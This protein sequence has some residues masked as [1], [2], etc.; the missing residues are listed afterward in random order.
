MK[1]SLFLILIFQSSFI[2]FD[3]N[4]N[5]QSKQKE[6]LVLG[7]ACSYNR[8]ISYSKVQIFHS[9]IEAENT[10]NKIMQFVSLP[11]NFI[12]K[13][14]NVDNAAATILKSGNTFKRFILYNPKFINSVKIATGNDFSGWSVLAHEIGHHLS[15]HTL[16]STSSSYKQELEADEF[17]GFVMYKMGATLIQAKSAINKFCDD[18]GS[19]THPPKKLRLSAVEK[20]WY[21]AKSTS[22]N[23][24]KI[25]G[26]SVDNNLIYKGSNVVMIFQNTSTG[27]DEIQEIIGY[28]PIMKY[29][30]D[31]KKWFIIYN[32]P[33]GKLVKM[34]LTF[35]ESTD[36]GS[37]MKDQEGT[38][39]EVMNGVN[40]DGILFCKLM[41]Y[42]GDYF[43]YLSFE[44][45][46]KR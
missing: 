34:D 27:N 10:I 37:I 20:G 40:R 29:F 16:G 41:N 42:T 24:A 45:L 32:E 38:K 21:N 19:K 43:V 30:L 3:N 7:K 35:L 6:W 22:P 13:A 44:G 26:G 4:L 8:D 14:S 17:S 11:A 15:G 12:V 9:E 25:D 36:D 2:E 33:D 1:W 18:V 5:L 28:N 23:I 39:Y 31:E 46:R